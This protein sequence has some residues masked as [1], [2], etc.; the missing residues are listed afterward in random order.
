MSEAAL[1]TLFQDPI[2]NVMDGLDTYIADFS[3]PDPLPP[4]WLGQ[5][6]QMARLGEY[7][8]PEPEEKESEVEGEA[9]AAPAPEIAAE[10][11][12]PCPTLA[13]ARPAER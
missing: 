9:A 3:Q 2:F 6:N 1:R 7:R 13:P 4:E 12:V 10:S 11:V 8:E 5:L